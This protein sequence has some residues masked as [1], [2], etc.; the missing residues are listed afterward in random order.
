MTVYVINNMKIH[1][2]QEYQH[3]LRSFAAILQAY[4][5]QLLAAEDDP[6]P[7][8]GEW[9]FDRTVVLA[10]PSAEHCNDWLHSPAYQRIAVHR[11]SAARTNMLVLKGEPPAVAARR[12]HTSVLP[13]PSD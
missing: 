5:G 7:T 1:E 8:E 11:W 4:G 10:F 6:I 9:P 12:L 3:Y 2:P 13:A